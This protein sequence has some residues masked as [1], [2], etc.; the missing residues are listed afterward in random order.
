MF[1]SFDTVEPDVIE[2]N[3]LGFEGSRFRVSVL[4]VIRTYDENL[5]QVSKHVL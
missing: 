2:F 5:A 3:P 4:V 1:L